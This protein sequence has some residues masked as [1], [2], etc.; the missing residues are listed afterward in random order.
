MTYTQSYSRTSTYTDSRACVVMK[1]ALND[2]IG[3]FTTDLI[4][5][6]TALKWYK[7]ILYVLS[8]EAA[9]FFEI[10]FRSSSLEQC[11][12]RYEISDDGYIYEDSESGGIDYYGLPNDT[13]V[14]LFLKIRTNSPNYDEVLQELENNRGWGTNGKALENSIVRDRAYSKDGYGLFRN[15]V[16]QW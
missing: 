16:G 3:L 8:K 5:K 2:I 11:G 7:D 15:K 14:Y 1:K 12:I 10:Q 4:T 13:Q 6:D 9:D